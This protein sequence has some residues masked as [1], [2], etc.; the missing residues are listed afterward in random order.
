[1]KYEDDIIINCIR[2]SFPHREKHYLPHKYSV[3]FTLTNTCFFAVA[4]D[5]FDQ[6]YYHPRSERCEWTKDIR[7]LFE[8]TKKVHTD[9]YRIRTK[10]IRIEKIQCT[11]QD[12]ICYCEMAFKKLKIS[13][14][15]KVCSMFGSDGFS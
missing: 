13:I 10:N 7:R 3:L 1:M 2:L 12:G 8:K 4:R 5:V 14:R 6:T 9:A 15:E 11:Y